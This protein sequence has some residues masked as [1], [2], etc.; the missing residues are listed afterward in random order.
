[1]QFAAEV[2]IHMTNKIEKSCA[3]QV[4]KTYNGP[5]WFTI[6]GAWTLQRYI[7][8][9]LSSELTSLVGTGAWVRVPQ[10]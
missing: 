2:H 6:A 10:Q 3:L 5:N 1:M 9:E 7:I 4:C 8:Y